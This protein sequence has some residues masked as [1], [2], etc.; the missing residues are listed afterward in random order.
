MALAALPGN[1]NLRGNEEN[2]N[3]TFEIFAKPAEYCL[4]TINFPK[5][6]RVGVHGKFGIG[7]WRVYGRKGKENGASGVSLRPPR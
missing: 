5:W 3:S 1:F 7:L 4:L 2:N 6:V